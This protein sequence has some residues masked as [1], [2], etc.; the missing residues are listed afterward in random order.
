MQTLPQ[1]NI[2][3]GELQRGYYLYV[4]HAQHSGPRTLIVAF[5]GGGGIGVKFPQQARFEE[6][7]ESEGIILAFPQGYEYPGNEGEWQLNTRPDAAHDINFI[8]AMIDEIASRHAIDRNRV[9]ATGYSLG[10]MF[11]YEVA[12]NMSDHFAAF[13]SFAGTMPV[14]PAQ[15][16]PQQSRP[17]MHIHGRNDPIISYSNR[18]GWKAWDEVGRMMDIPSLVQYWRNKHQCRSENTNESSGSTHYVYGDCK[19]NA[20]V[21]HHR[22]DGTGHDWPDEING[23]STHQVIWSFFRQFKR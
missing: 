16:T 5:H 20:R 18:W 8:K 14:K 2:S 21:E 10:S 4:P 15:C 23:L 11:T 7:A 3:V 6:L 1:Q 22:I 9:Y 12:C 17:I 19:Q 13:A